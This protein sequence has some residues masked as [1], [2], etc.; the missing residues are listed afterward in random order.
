MMKEEIIQLY[1]RKYY[2]DPELIEWVVGV[3]A[4]QHAAKVMSCLSKHLPFSSIE[5]LTLP[6]LKRASSINTPAGSIFILLMPN[7]MVNHI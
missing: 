4:K 6:H 7:S 1:P 5:D 3:V 2:E